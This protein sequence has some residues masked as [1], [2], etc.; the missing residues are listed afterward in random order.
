MYELASVVTTLSTHT[1]GSGDADVA[2]RPASTVKIITASVALQVLGADFTY[3]TELRGYVQG[4]ARL[5]AP[6]YVDEGGGA[7]APFLGKMRTVAAL[8]FLSMP[9]NENAMGKPD[10]RHQNEFQEKELRPHPI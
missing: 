8:R 1:R 6:S 4:A 5:Y 10:W 7:P 3:T 2:L 9:N